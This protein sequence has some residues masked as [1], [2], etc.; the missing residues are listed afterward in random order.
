MPQDPNPLPFPL[1]RRRSAHNSQAF[2][3]PCKR[4]FTDVL[5]ICKTDPLSEGSR[6]NY[7]CY[8]VPFLTGISGSKP[9]SRAIPTAIA[10]EEKAALLWKIGT[11]ARQQSTT[12][13]ARPADADGCAAAY[14]RRGGRQHGEICLTRRAGRDWLHPPPAT[15]AYC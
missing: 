8:Y 3:H 11:H 5:L 13:A 10:P 4:P 1:V 9:P 15:A 2:G 6:T 14:R 7:D 12:P